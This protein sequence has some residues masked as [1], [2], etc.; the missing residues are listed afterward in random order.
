MKYTATVLC[1]VGILF[2]LLS[3]VVTQSAEKRLT[4]LTTTFPLYQFTRNITRGVAGV[5][6]ELMIPA[7]TG[8]PHDYFLTPQDMR[9][10]SRADVLVVNGLGLE[11]FLSGPI[12][13]AGPGLR[14]I[15]SSAGIEEV[16]SYKETDF[17]A[18]DKH[19]HHPEGREQQFEQHALNHT[20]NPHL[21]ASPRMAALLVKNIGRAM[22]RL[23][24]SHA[25]QYAA[26]T[27]QYGR[28][29]GELDRAFADLGKRLKNNRIVTQHGVFDYL[30]RDMGLQV[31]AVV[32]AHAGQQPSAAEILHITRIIK[33]R[34]AGAVFT[35]PQYPEA[36]G[37][38]IARETALPV[39]RLDPVASG[40]Q[41]AP[42]DYYEQVMQQNYLT[43]EQTLGSN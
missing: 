40:P 30:A 6:V 2:L 23:D 9:K 29:L 17:D 28:Q 33:N 4:V 18:S 32:Q 1:F 42:L 35:E 21:F 13:K 16:I 37:A 31:V 7:Q 5:T 34:H 12:Q 27:R 11:D 26:N 19:D 3:P 25:A 41:Q 36:V 20:L 14:V 22:A 24:S 38:A 15:D 39:A 43:L 8:C 10:L